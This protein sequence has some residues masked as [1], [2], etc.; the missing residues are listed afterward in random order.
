MA[1]HPVFLQSCCA[2]SRAI[3]PER[4]TSGTSSDRSR[5]SFPSHRFSPDQAI[6]SLPTISTRS[7]V[8]ALWIVALLLLYTASPVR[9]EGSSAAWSATGGGSF[10]YTDDVAL[11]S[12]TRRS[13]LDGDPSQP[14]LDV[15]RTGVGKDMVFEPY[16]RLS[17]LVPSRWGETEFSARVRGFVYGSNPEF[18]QSSIYL[19]AV[20]G[21]TPRTILRLRYFTAP[22]QLL[23]LTELH[24]S[25]ELHDMRVTS[26]LGTVRLDHRLSEHWEIQFLARAGIRNFNDP[27]RQRDTLLW[28]VGPHLLYHLNHH[29]KV[30]LGYQYE[31]GLAE[32]RH[33]AH[34]EDDASYVHHFASIGLEADLMEHLEL[35]LDFHYERNNFT[36]GMPH[37]E[38]F[39]GHE[40]IYIGSG[41][42]SY[43]LT[44]HTALTLTVQRSNR[45]ISF[46]HTHDFNT[47][48]SAGG[49]YRF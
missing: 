26:H 10:F 15:S 30:I 19:E 40:N 20:H 49:V 17:K 1:N 2:N 9:A 38:R 16:V 33:D 39:G 11:F 8:S 35:E 5:N 29:A 36:T 44:D 23:G 25:H 47:N 37:D 43:Q 32:G 46:H 3:G 27:F 42:L 48:V 45:E 24:G 34:L 18:S 21:F 4:S 31:R 6:T 28:R 7:C 13:S 41:R 12:A 22:D 14:V